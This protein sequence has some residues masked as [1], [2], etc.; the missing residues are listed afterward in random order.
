MEKSDRCFLCGR[1]A[2]C[3]FK[4]KAIC[5]TH[6]ELITKDNFLK[7]YFTK[8]LPLIIIEKEEKLWKKKNS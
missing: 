2:K 1:K 7:K 6:Y 4:S 8:T 3:F 5:R